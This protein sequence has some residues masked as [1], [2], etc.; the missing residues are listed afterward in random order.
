MSECLPA[1]APEQDAACAE[2]LQGA[3]A[4]TAILAGDAGA[5]AASPPSPG[6]TTSDG[7]LPEDFV[8]TRALKWHRRFL[9]V[10]GLV[11]DWS[12]DPSTRVGAVI[13]DDER[14]IVSTGYNGL[15][16][17]V[18]DLPDY[19]EDRS[20]KYPMII[21]AEHNAV[22]TARERDLRNCTLY[23]THAPC[24]RCTA[25]AIQAGIRRFVAPMPE[26]DYLSRWMEDLRISA[27]LRGHSGSRLLL[28]EGRE[29]LQEEAIASSCGYIC[30]G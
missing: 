20:L 30:H 24:S 17:G 10:A 13:V 4:L 16:R 27:L 29:Q 7:E 5:S 3:D 14:R 11:A 12:K 9:D 8:S 25:A 23:A 22:L 2:S 6:I 28:L 19:L 1:H 15:P 21:H 26:G 18:P